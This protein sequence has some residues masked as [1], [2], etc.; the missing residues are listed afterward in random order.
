LTFRLPAFSCLR[1]EQSVCCV[2]DS[3]IRCQSPEN[4]HHK[5]QTG[6]EKLLLIIGSHL[7]DFDAC[8]HQKTIPLLSQELALEV[9]SR[10][11]RTQVG[12]VG[13]HLFS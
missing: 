1:D 10:F 3:H 2:F 9:G 5:N 12:V 8:V 7:A 13:G 6:S 4:V 11:L